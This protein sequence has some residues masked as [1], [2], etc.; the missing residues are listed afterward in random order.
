[1]TDSFSGFN[2]LVWSG[3]EREFAYVDRAPDA[4]SEQLGA[5]VFRKLVELDAE[6][7]ERFH[8]ASRAHR[9]PIAT[10]GQIAFQTPHFV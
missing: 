8:F 6:K 2:L 4:A 10:R 1:M 9:Q 7:S 3:T 5:R